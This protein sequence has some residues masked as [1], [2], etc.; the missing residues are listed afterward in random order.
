MIHA[1]VWTVLVLHQLSGRG[2]GRAVRH[3]VWRQVDDGAVLG[4]A[5]I[6]GDN[7]TITVT[8]WFVITSDRTCRT[9]GAG[10]YSDILHFSVIFGV[11]QISI[12]HNHALGACILL[13]NG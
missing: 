10:S 1:W 2:R 4:S 8:F 7:V 3:R 9:H 6:D 11:E 12:V 13:M 5:P